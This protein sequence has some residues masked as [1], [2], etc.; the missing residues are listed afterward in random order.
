M[1][2]TY[3]GI[4]NRVSG[5]ALLV[6]RITIVLM[7]V[8]LLRSDVRGQSLIDPLDYPFGTVKSTR[9]YILWQDIYNERDRDLNVRYRLTLERDSTVAAAPV[10]YTFMPQLYYRSVY[11]WKIPEPLPEGSYRYT[12]ERLLNGHGVKSRHY[13]IRRYPIRR[14]F[15]LNTAAE[16]ELDDLRPEY[17][18]QYIYIDRNNTLNNG[19][20][21]I[22]FASS[23]T[24]TLGIG[25]LFY[26]VIDLGVWSTVISAI[27][28]TSSAVGYSAAG[29]YTWHYSKNRRKLQKILEIG[30]STTIRGGIIDRTVT[31]EAEL[32]F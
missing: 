24:V 15:T 28:F 14:S 10:V 13:H 25:I 6:F 5:I 2:Q 17:L 29:Y 18:V 3:K 31:A 7:S 9:P 16:N 19:Y 26:T 22:F 20:N 32:S 21:A 8:F 12:I 27:C 1:G 11:L 4:Q 23:S 30:R